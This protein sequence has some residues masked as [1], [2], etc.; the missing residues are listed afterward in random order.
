[1]QPTSEDPNGGIGK[2]LN[3]LYFTCLNLTKKTFLAM[4]EGFSILQS[5]RP[6]ANSRSQP[7]LLPGERKEI[8]RGE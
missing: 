1:M 8:N 5:C 3:M 6:K 4:C 2:D 7:S